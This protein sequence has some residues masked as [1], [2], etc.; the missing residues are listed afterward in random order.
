MRRKS[1]SA[2]F[3]REQTDLAAQYPGI[4][5][6]LERIMELEHTPPAV[7]KFRIKALDE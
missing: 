4:V 5:A 7:P 2:I 3:S 6:E 1:Q